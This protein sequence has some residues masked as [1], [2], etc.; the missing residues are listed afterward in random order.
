MPKTFIPL[1]EEMLARIMPFSTAAHRK[2]YLPLLNDA[3]R[4]SEIIGAKREAAFLAQIAHE[5]GSLSFKEEVG[6]GV[7][8]EWR[9]DLGNVNKGDGPRYK[10]RGFLMITGRA[11]YRH[12]GNLL[13]LPLEEKPELAAEPGIAMNIAGVYWQEHGCNQL[14]DQLNFK[15]ITRKI[16][17]GLNGYQSRLEFYTRALKALTPKIESRSSATVAQ[18]ATTVD[19][20][21][22]KSPSL[23]T[24]LN[25]THIDAEQTKTPET[26]LPLPA[27][28]L[29][30]QNFDLITWLNDMLSR[31]RN[32][33]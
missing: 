1:T 2:A 24:V 21:P 20:T 8:Y 30:A 33:F 5:S 18:G 15:A 31:I 25:D 12:Y 3:M 4:K 27:V 22:V 32:L 16:N 7:Q 23:D 17:G 10:G 28:T 26:A 29:P 14:A 19:S 6:S 9:S 13:N 11:N